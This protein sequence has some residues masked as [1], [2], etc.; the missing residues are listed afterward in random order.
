MKKSIVIVGGVLILFG[1][2]LGAMGAHALKEV[3]TDK[4]MASFETGVR[5]QMYMGLAI[6]ALG[7][8]YSK[9]RKR[10]FKL[11]IGFILSGAILFSLSIYGLV[12]ADTVGASLKM[13]FGPITPLGGVLM[14]VGWLLFIL[15]FF[16]HD[17]ET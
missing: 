11:F 5:Y 15:Q 16:T 17:D 12:W 7:L 9:F 2:I 8:N 13:V 3:L 14:I 1:I 6:L 10:S 4:N